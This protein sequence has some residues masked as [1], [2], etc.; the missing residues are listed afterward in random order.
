MEV[1][2]YAFKIVNADYRLPT[3]VEGSVMVTVGVA[4]HFTTV[5][6]ALAWLLTMGYVEVTNS[7]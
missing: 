2:D 5:E 1:K 6:D 7:E 4:T 3:P